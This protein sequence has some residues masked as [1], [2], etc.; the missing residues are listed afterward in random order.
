MS[1]RTPFLVGLVLIMAVSGLT[2]FFMNTSKDKFD[3]ASTYPLVADFTDASGI[4]WKTRVQINGIDV[5]KIAGINHA[6]GAQGRLVARVTLRIANEYEIYDNAMVAK[7]AESLLGD[8]R[9][10]LDP[11]TP[12]ARKLGAWRDHSQRAQPLGPRRNQEPVVAGLAQ[13]Q[14]SDAELPKSARRALRARDR[15]RPSCT[16]WKIR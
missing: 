1:P 2:Y 5:G 12:D 13:C 8:F 4:R 6:R 14:R 7:A 15:S 10:D 9:I 3:E 11:G 16:R